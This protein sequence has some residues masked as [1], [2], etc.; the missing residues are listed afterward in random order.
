ELGGGLPYYVVGKNMDTQEVFVTKNLNDAALWRKE[1][2]LGSVHW[3]DEPL[4][5]GASCQ[6]RTRHRGALVPAVFGRGPEGA[7]VI[8]DEPER[9]VSPGQSVVIYQEGE[10]LG[11]GI[12]I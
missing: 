9:A 8:L 1:L 10:C 4:S 2:R 7:V 3:I 5:E 6:V 11:G 12:V